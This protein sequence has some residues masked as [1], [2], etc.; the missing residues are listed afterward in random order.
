MFVSR[1]FSAIFI[2]KM[3]TEIGVAIVFMI[4]GLVIMYACNVFKDKE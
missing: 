3:E 4:I 1:R 2:K